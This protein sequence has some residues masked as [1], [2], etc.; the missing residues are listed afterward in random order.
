MYLCLTVHVIVVVQ[1]L[2]VQLI[3]IRHHKSSISYVHSRY[4]VPECHFRPSQNM[5][6]HKKDCHV[7]DVSLV[8]LHAVEVTASS[9]WVM[10]YL[11][12]SCHAKN[13]KGGSQR[14]AAA[15]MVT[16]IF[17][18]CNI[19]ECKALDVK[20]CDLP[21]C[22]IP[23]RRDGWC[24]CCSNVVKVLTAQHGFG[25]ASSILSVSAFFR[26]AVDGGCPALHHWR[27]MVVSDLA[28]QLDACV[29]ASSKTSCNDVP[30]LISPKKAR[31]LTSILK[32]QAGVGVGTSDD[33][34]ASKVFVVNRD[35][36]TSQREAESAQMASYLSTGTCLMA[37]SLQV[38]MSVD[39]SSVSSRE[40]LTLAV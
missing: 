31:R 35:R 6:K 10:A 12:M 18:Y 15:N 16:R 36:G 29:V 23:F 37:G 17:T 25:W 32:S 27:V 24:Q 8:E 40:L 38:G 19:S 9:L 26:E 11:A 20:P 30:V 21:E 39:C 28:K 2:V 34:G 3:A 14:Q 22:P 13:G 33:A 1:L 5:V 7:D 4:G